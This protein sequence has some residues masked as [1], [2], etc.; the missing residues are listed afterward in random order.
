MKKYNYISLLLVGIITCSCTN[1]HV[2]EKSNLNSLITEK[3]SIKEPQQVEVSLEQLVGT[4]KY[5]EVRVE[6]NSEGIKPV[7]G[8]ILMGIT[9]DYKIAF[10]TDGEE[11]LIQ[12]LELLYSEFKIVDNQ[13]CAVDENDIT[14]KINF[15]RTCLPVYL[16][17]EK[18]LVIGK[19]KDSENKDKPIIYQYYKKR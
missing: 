12:N 3:N 4:W 6:P 13:I 9:D 2:D 15:Q 1:N 8:T 10:A 7:G 11:E 18:E 5:A 19:G 14:F 17:N 16:I